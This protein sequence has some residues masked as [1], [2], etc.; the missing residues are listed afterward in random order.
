[1]QLQCRR[2]PKLIG[3]DEVA[4]LVAVRGSGYTLSSELD[5]CIIVC[6]QCLDVKE[7][8]FQENGY[9]YIPK[10][11]PEPQLTE[12]EA[13]LLEQVALGRVYRLPRRVMFHDPVT[14]TDK[15]CTDH[16]YKLLS[17]KYVRWEVVPDTEKLP[18]G[19]NAWMRITED[20]RDFLS[21]HGVMVKT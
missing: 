5:Q 14:N 12:K 20:G 4:H 19:P 7:K 3:E 17:I 1:M 2:C 9:V 21:R 18:G 10:P 11:V 16:A 13:R 15:R 8:P 6:S